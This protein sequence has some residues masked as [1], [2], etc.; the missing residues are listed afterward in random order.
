MRDMAASLGLYG[1]G[2]MGS[3]LALNILERGFPLHVAN[4]TAAKVPALPGRG[5]A[6][7]GTAPRGTRGSRRWPRR[8]RRPAR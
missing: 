8:W 2:T 3:A 7:G 5:R 6:A 4:R 1:L